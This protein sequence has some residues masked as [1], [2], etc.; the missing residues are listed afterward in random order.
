MSVASDDLDSL[1]AA[2]PAGFIEER[3]RIVA[4]LKSAGRKDEAKAVEKIPR[5]SLALWTVNQI[6]RRDPELV[7]RLSEVT[8]R[9]QTAPISEYATAAVEHRQVLHQLRDRASE[10]LAGAGLEITPQ[11][12]LR[13]IANLRAAAGSPDTRATLEQGRMVRDLAEQA[14][15][16]LFGSAAAPADGAAS[17]PAAAAAD[18]APTA[19]PAET[20][21]QTRVRTKEIVQA[22]REVK[23]LRGAEAAARKK[24]ERAERAVAAARESIAV[25]EVHAATAR[26]DAEAAEK[27]R[28][29]AEAAL[30]RLSG[31]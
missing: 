26:A 11:V 27:A 1:F 30:A 23:R 15:E 20:T 22:E 14:S 25:A 12:I 29:D 18:S 31:A 3:K 28:A 13:A 6:A 8:E 10:I 16:S 9:L 7:R 19:A 17:S 24:V 2:P 21:A 4:A 5:P